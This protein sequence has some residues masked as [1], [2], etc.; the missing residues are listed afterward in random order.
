MTEERQNPLDNWVTFP[1]SVLLSR[2]DV[3]PSESIGW[4]LNL[5]IA[6]SPR[7]VFEYVKAQL[8]TAGFYQEGA[9]ESGPPLF[10]LMKQDAYV[11]GMVRAASGGTHLFLSTSPEPEEPAPPA[12]WDPGLSN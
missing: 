3:L 11:W 2:Q 9:E 8:I 6:M 1:E 5:L 10:R 4:G 12:D 7:M